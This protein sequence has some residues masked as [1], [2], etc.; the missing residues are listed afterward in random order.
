MRTLGSITL[1]NLLVGGD[2]VICRA[3]V[4]ALQGPDCN[5][6]FFCATSLDE[7][8]TLENVQILLLALGWITE[9]HGVSRTEIGD[10]MSRMKIPIL[11]LVAP[12]EEREH[13]L[14]R[15]VAF[16]GLAVPTS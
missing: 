14:G 12:F 11:K 5:A 7:V 10:L 2:P 16:P 1:I 6:R 3:L 8:R 13:R 15:S 9:R 4:L